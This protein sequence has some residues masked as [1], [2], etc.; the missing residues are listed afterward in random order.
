MFLAAI[1][2][3]WIGRKCNLSV[4]FQLVTVYRVTLE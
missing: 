3:G 2:V 1:W 4:F